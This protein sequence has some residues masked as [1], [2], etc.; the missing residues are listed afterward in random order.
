MPME[1]MNGL[2]TFETKNKNPSVLFSPP[3]LSFCL[4][5]SLWSSCVVLPLLALTWMSA[6]LA[7]TDKRSILFQILFAVFD[8]LQGFVIVMVHCILRKE[9]GLA[10]YNPLLFFSFPSAFQQIVFKFFRVPVYFTPCL[11][12]LKVYIWIFYHHFL[13]IM[14]F[15]ITSLF[16]WNTKEVWTVL[17]K[18]EVF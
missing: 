11:V 8:S 10:H 15:R 1:K 4:R 3:S 14:L 13:I 2:K 16:L 18:F 6:V 7:M 5:A 17:T 9:V 12:L